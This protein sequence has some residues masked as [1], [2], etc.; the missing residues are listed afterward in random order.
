M[1]KLVAGLQAVATQYPLT[2]IYTVSTRKKLDAHAF[3]INSN[4]M[5]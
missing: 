5:Y 2:V 3:D 4:I 1:S